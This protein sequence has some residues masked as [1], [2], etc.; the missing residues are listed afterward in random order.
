MTPNLPAAPLSANTQIN[1]Q[2][3]YS[4]PTNSI[5]S[6]SSFPSKEG[7]IKD[8]KKWSVYV[9]DHSC[10]SKV[11]YHLGSFDKE[12]EANRLY[13]KVGIIKLKKNY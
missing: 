8:G 9:F 1:M 12:D 6:S 13:V 5:P 2:T 4:N 3:S 10:G 7:V 11:L